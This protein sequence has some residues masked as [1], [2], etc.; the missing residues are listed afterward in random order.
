M[1]PQSVLVH[2]RTCTVKLNTLEV[3]HQ[4]I[5]EQPTQ[6]ANSYTISGPFVFIYIPRELLGERNGESTYLNAF[7]L[8]TELACSCSLVTRRILY[9][10]YNRTSTAD[11]GELITRNS[12]IVEPTTWNTVLLYYHHNLII[13]RALQKVELDIGFFQQF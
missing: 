3:F 12:H 5:Q 8:L 11:E 4:V 2:V 6:N 10:Y 9:R 7:L 1:I 13:Y